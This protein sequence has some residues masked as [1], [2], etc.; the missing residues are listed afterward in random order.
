MA[1]DFAP[2]AHLGTP[3]ELKEL[4]DALHQ[5]E[6]G[7]VLSWPPLGLP[8][9]GRPLAPDDEEAAAALVEGEPSFG[10]V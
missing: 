10:P 2:A 7:V 8:V 9:D 3:D 6:V 1:G 5:R 4:V